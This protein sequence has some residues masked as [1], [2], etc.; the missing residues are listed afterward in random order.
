MSKISNFVLAIHDISKHVQSQTHVF[1]I[2]F[3][4]LGWQV[5]DNC[6]QKLSNKEMQIKQNFDFLFHSFNRTKN[7]Y[8]TAV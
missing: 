3:Q 2:A 1:G 5:V 7:E 4:E 6:G 8:F